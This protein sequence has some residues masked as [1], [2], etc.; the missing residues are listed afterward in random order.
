M[1]NKFLNERE[2]NFYASISNEYMQTLNSTVLLYKIDTTKTNQHSLYAN[3]R[4][5]QR[6]YILPAIE[7]LCRVN[8]TDPDHKNYTDG[9]MPTRYEEYGQLKVHILK[10]TLELL[11]VDFEVSDIVEYNINGQRLFFEVTSPNDAMVQNSTT[12]GGFRSFWK[13]IICAPTN[14]SQTNLA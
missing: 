3:A 13:T 12:F 2:Y 10:S 4:R 9:A 5:N 14:L 1:S 8:L 7:I 6:M 11:K